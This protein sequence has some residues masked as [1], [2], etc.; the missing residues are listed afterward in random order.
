M[1]LSINYRGG[2]IIN[3]C[4]PL[5]HT[6]VTAMDYLEVQNES[7]DICSDVHMLEQIGN[8]SSHNQ[9]NDL[10][11]LIRISQHNKPKKSHI[12]QVEPQGN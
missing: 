3:L 7:T 10:E 2:R 1:F 12:A 11:T 6:D 5:M 9:E 8:P 4:F